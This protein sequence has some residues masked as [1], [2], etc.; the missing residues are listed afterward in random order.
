MKGLEHLGRGRPPRKPELGWTLVD[1]PEIQIELAL[2]AYRK[3]HHQ[4]G[5]DIAHWQKNKEAIQEAAMA[6]WYGDPD[7]PS[8]YAARF[9]RYLKEN[10]H[11]VI[12]ATNTAELESF[13]TTLAKQKVEVH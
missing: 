12:D 6:D 7:D 11:K 1:A 9:R 2:F 4:P 5:V 10:P 13:L 3:V 8:S